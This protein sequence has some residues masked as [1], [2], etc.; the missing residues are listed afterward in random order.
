MSRERLWNLSPPPPP[1][2]LKAFRGVPPAA[3]QIAYNRGIANPSEL[4]TFLTPDKRLLPDPL[5]LPDMDRALERLEEA[6]RQEEL[7]AIYGDFDADGVTATALLHEGLSKLGGRTTPYI[8]HRTEEGHG[9]SPQGVAAV[10]DLGASLIL[11]ADCGVS[12]F[13]EVEAASDMGIDVLITDHHSPPPDLP[14]A[15]AVIDPKLKGSQYPSQNLAAV[16]V[17]YR[18]VQALSGRVGEPEDESLLDL[19]ALGTVADL[20]PLRDENRYLVKRGIEVLNA[21]TR[22]GIREMFVL[23]GLS[24]GEIGTEAISFALGPRINAAG[25]VDHAMTSYRLLTATSAAEARPLAEELELRNRERQR[26]SAEVLERAIEQVE[27]VGVEQLLIMV[28]AEEYSPGVIGLA[29]GKLVEQF[30]RPAIV[31]TLGKE[32]V[33]ASARSIPEF[34]I[35][36][37]LRQCRD[38]FL[39]F[40]GHSQAAGFIIA[41]ENLEILKSRLLSI[42]E[43]KLSGLQLQPSIQIDVQIPLRDLEGRLIKFVGL[44]EPCGNGNPHP[45][46]LSKGTR[47]V[48]VR[49]LGEEGRHLKLKLRDG[50]AVWDA[51][52]FGLGSRAEGLA[53]RLDIVYQLKA[54]RRG[55]HEAL[56]LEILDLAPSRD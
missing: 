47:V 52:G 36:D 27:A 16:G 34:N 26:Q 50:S 28:G 12:S 44:L 55:G 18:L 40:G 3:T 39:R 30:Y 23:A 31:M 38:L 19:V 20:A 15:L 41:K 13:D 32:I 14:H 33:R 45:T 29:A 56:Q 22:P 54:D 2:Y 43:E 10:R 37:A 17:V 6:F 25:R 46:F 48:E 1:E 5:L 53:S 8:P 24:L 51:I 21:T 11:T 35:I 7:I 9:L 4:R 42:A 49:Q